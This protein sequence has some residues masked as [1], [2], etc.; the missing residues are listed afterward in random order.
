[1]NYKDVLSLDIIT[2]GDLGH[3][4]RAAAADSILPEVY[5]RAEVVMLPD[6]GGPALGWDGTCF[7]KEV[8][9]RTGSGNDM[10]LLVE[11]FPINRHDVPLLTEYEQVKFCGDCKGSNG[12]CPGFAPRFEWLRSKCEDFIVVTISIDMIWPIMYATPRDGWVGRRVLKQLVYADRLTDCYGH[13][14]LKAVRKDGHVLD[15]G[16]CPGC[17]PSRCTV[18]RGEKCRLPKKRTFSMEAVG[19]DCDELHKMFYG[20]QLPWYY[21]GTSKIPAYM[22]RYIGIFPHRYKYS[23]RRTVQGI[24]RFCES[25]KSYIPAAEVPA[26]RE[27]TVSLQ[28]IPHG[29]YAEHFQYVYNDPGLVEQGQV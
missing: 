15:M 10:S 26:P 6:P 28:K 16:N 1:M 8:G 11:I 24:A 7:S 5:D 3:A 14:M 19:V 21:K 29:V 9:Y 2:T 18:I 17:R 23:W 12:G 22:T 13:R 25:D 4:R 20:E 27:A